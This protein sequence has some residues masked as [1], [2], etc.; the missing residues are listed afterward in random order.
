MPEQPVT[1]TEEGGKVTLQL[2]GGT[3]PASAAAGKD[4]SGSASGVRM[5]MDPG[6][7]LVGTLSK[8]QKSMTIDLGAIGSVTLQKQSDQG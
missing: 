7:L 8:D 6:A 5:K 3:K 1:W 2:Q 4:T